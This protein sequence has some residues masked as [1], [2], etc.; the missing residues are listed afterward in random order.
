MVLSKIFRVFHFHVG[1]PGC[2]LHVSHIKVR[3]LL[4]SKM[5]IIWKS[6]VSCLTCMFVLVFPP[7]V[8]CILFQDALN[9]LVLKDMRSN[10]ENLSQPVLAVELVKKESI[11]GFHNNRKLPFLKIT[12]ALPRLIASAKRLL[13]Q[14]FACPGFQSDIYQA[15]ESDVGFEIR[16]VK[17]IS[18]Y[19]KTFL[20]WVTNRPTLSGPFR[21]VVGLGSWTYRYRWSFG[22]QIK[23][24]I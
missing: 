9:S 20:N 3:K 6:N 1:N 16:L 17:L 2:K 8:L 18:E 24:S 19:S 10:R 21:E 12:M 15:Y 23:W 13:G 11:Y 14:G 22:T 7:H 4:M 5:I